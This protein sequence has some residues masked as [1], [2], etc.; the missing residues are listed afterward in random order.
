M[1]ALFENNATPA[2]VDNSSKWQ[3]SLEAA[4]VAMTPR[5]QPWAAGGQAAAAGM[6]SMSS[7]QRM[8]GGGGGGGLLSSFGSPGPRPVTARAGAGGKSVLFGGPPARPSSAP[9]ER[10]PPSRSA[11]GGGAGDAMA[12]VAELRHI[13]EAQY[14]GRDVPAKRDLPAY[15][16]ISA[17]GQ[18]FNDERLFTGAT[19][20]FQILEPSGLSKA[21]PRLAG[22]ATEQQASLRKWVVALGGLQMGSV[23]WLP[24]ACSVLFR[25]L[26][27]GK[28]Y[29]NRSDLAPIMAGKG[30]E[31]LQET[32]RV[33]VLSR[34][35]AHQRVHALRNCLDRDTRAPDFQPWTQRVWDRLD[36]RFWKRNKEIAIRL[37]NQRLENMMRRHLRYLSEQRCA[38]ARAP[39]ARTK[40]VLREAFWRVDPSHSGLVSLQQF[41]QV[42]QNVLLLLEYTDDE[43]LLPS[44]RTRKVLTPGRRFLMDQNMCASLFVKYGFDK[45]GLLPYV[46]FIT[47]LTAAPARLLGQEVVLDKADEGKHGLSCETDIAYV[48]GD[49][50][51]IYPKCEGGV[52][53]P[54]HFDPRVAERSRLPP[55]AHM[56][57]EHVYGYAGA[58]SLDSN[59]WYTA[60]TTETK[61]ECVYYAG[62]VGIVF[63]KEAYDQGRPSQRFFFGHNQDIQ[64]LTMHPS[65]RF[66]ATGQQKAVGPTEV[67]YVCIWDVDNC[68]LLQRLDHAEEERSVIAGCFSGN[69][70]TGHGGDIFVSVTSDDRHTLHIWR[71]MKGSDP[72][73]KTHPYQTKIS[74]VSFQVTSYGM[75]RMQA[76]NIPGWSFGP[77]K[78]LE[79]IRQDGEYY[80]NREDTDEDGNA[81]PWLQR[82]DDDTAYRHYKE[83]KAAEPPHP[84]I[85]RVAN[86]ANKVLTKWELGYCTGTPPMRNDGTWEKLDEL[87]GCNG[88]PPMVYGVVWNPWSTAGWN[89][90]SEF[91]SYGVKHMKTWVLTRRNE[92]QRGE[93]TKQDDDLVWRGTSATFGTDHVVNV[94]SAAYVPAMH[95]MAARGDVCIL[96]GFASGQVTKAQT[97]LVRVPFPARLAA[98]RVAGVQVGLWI[99]PYPTRAGSVYALAR[100][101]D[102]HGQGALR[103]MN[104]GTQQ[105]GG[106]RVIRLRACPSGKRSCGTQ[107]LTAGS[108]GC[109]VQWQLEPVTGT[110]KTSLSQPRACSHLLALLR[111]R[112]LGLSAAAA[113]VIKLVPTAHALYLSLYLLLVTWLLLVNVSPEAHSVVA[114]AM[115]QDG[116]PLRGVSLRCLALSSQETNGPN[117]FLLQGPLAPCQ[118]SQPPAIMALDCHPAKPAEFIAGTDGNDI[119]EVDSD[120][121]VL[122]EGHEQDIY[123]VEPHPSNPN[124]FVTG[125]GSGQVSAQAPPP[126]CRQPALLPYGGAQ[127]RLWD[128]TKREV[129]RSAAL[130][131]GIAG[132]ALSNEQYVCRASK[133]PA[134][135]LALGSAGGYSGVKHKIAVLDAATLQPLKVMLEPGAQVDAQPHVDELKYSPAGGPA[136]LAA[137]GRDMTI[138][139]YSAA[140]DYQLV[141]KCSGHSGNLEHLDWS[142]PINQPGSKLHM[143]MVLQASDASGN[144]LYWDPKTGR[145][146]PHSQRDAAWHT[147]TCRLGFPV[148]GIWPDDSDRTDVNSVTRSQRG[149]SKWDPPPPGQAVSGDALMQYLSPPEEENSADGVP[150]CGYLATGDDFSSVRLFNFPVVWDD[151][152]YKAF[153]GHSSHVMS[154]RFSCDDRHLL[155]AGGHDGCIFQWRTC[156]VAEA[157]HE[158]DQLILAAWRVAVMRRGQKDSVLEPTPGV[159]WDQLDAAGKVFGPKAAAVVHDTK[160][161]GLGEG[162]G[163]AGLEGAGKAGLSTT[164][165]ASVGPGQAATTLCMGRSAVVR[166]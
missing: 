118:T 1:T 41:L 159:E 107:L 15:W 97:S 153:K 34:L 109:V 164:T 77:Y 83:L 81:K 88:T 124:V 58:A 101:Y 72:F 163:P 24:A 119:W 38:A 165:T 61:T 62:C 30:V 56:W 136:M 54:S 57:L 132:I 128:L 146:I 120:P 43:V 60:N 129:S 9:R 86:R 39:A 10:P 25:S 69:I 3:S 137:G 154:A 96:T 161:A 130:G 98:S 155:S 22:P 19:N 145:K 158:A 53:P 71:W 48:V 110:R 112:L 134:T 160:K 149:A 147:W 4:E 37:A 80:V 84:L 114:L 143:S 16:S 76:Q 133:A 78:K 126:S 91:L 42:W 106:V 142:L 95:A 40:D 144:L 116:T 90:G 23:G 45:D 85:E 127:V 36:A 47:A 27:D 18:P 99:P 131:F 21:E 135:H 14:W 32:D 17:Y 51:I 75:A 79:Q 26:V 150:G 103:T 141:A 121:R 157:D 89:P 46:V 138:Y 11:G 74:N 162:L 113:R 63:D 115:L 105:Y 59:V 156:G 44:G 94:M 87:P 100:K 152:P 50:K 31:K 73:C 65:R 5:L 55:R 102:A 122:V 64:F 6:A 13:K 123:H 140:A 148:M 33:L 151:A 49:A 139:L 8:G 12:R 67:P 70:N 82:S 66:V 20:H 2:R 93:N 125:C 166:R 28:R 104:D 52:L 117:R 111:C 7:T 35:S 29:F 108:D 68:N 92:T